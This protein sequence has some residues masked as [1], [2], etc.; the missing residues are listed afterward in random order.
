MTLNVMDNA[1]KKGL[2]AT[3][4]GEP[5]RSGGEPNGVA[6]NPAATAVPI[7]NPEVSAKPQRHRFTP[8]YKARIV[9]EAQRCTAPHRH[10][11]RLATVDAVYMFLFHFCV[12]SE[13]INLIRTSSSESDAGRVLSGHSRNR[14]MKI[15][16]L[17]VDPQN[18]M[19]PLKSV[20]SIL[21]GKPWLTE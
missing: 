20:P 19:C 2:L 16:D 15:S 17:L 1:K 11:E 3:D 8:A 9:E 5:E 10:P 13:I 4:R 6:N 12:R 18:R 7:P 14:L 21:I